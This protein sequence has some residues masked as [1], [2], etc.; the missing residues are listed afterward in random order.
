MV[1]TLWTTREIA[2]EAR[3]RGR[4]V[5]QE[6]L[7]RLCKDG[8]LQAVKPGRDWLIHDHA[9]QRWLDDWLNNRQ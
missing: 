9:A 4:P 2:E 5:T 3:R 1:K 6:Y 8:T 7:Q